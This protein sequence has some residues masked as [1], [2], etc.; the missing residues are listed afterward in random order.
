MYTTR[1]PLCAS[2]AAPLWPAA[3]RH[4]RDLRNLLAARP[5]IA[6]W[7]KEHAR[8]RSP[9]DRCERRVR[10]PRT[11]LANHCHTGHPYQLRA[12]YS[13]RPAGPSTASPDEQWI[14]QIEHTLNELAQL[15]RDGK[16]ADLDDIRAHAANAIPGPLIEDSGIRGGDGEPIQRP[17]TQALINL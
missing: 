10:N 6:A 15:E 2:A 8:C 5:E 7:L 9:P 4:S 11:A 17:V 1:N 12:A 3:Q 16:T 13:L 14:W